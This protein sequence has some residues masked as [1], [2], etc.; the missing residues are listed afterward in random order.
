MIYYFECRNKSIGALFCV[1]NGSCCVYP[2]T[3]LAS[4]PDGWV[5]PDC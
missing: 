4:R 3:L 2:D 1:I 5:T